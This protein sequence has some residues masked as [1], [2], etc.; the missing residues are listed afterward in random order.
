MKIKFCVA[1]LFLLLNVLFTKAQNDSLSMFRSSDKRNNAAKTYYKNVLFLNCG[2]L[3]RGGFSI[4]YER[5][6]LFNGVSIFAQAG[7]TARDFTGQF[8]WSAFQSIFDNNDSDR[9]GLR[10]GYM[11][12]VGA[13]YYLQKSDNGKYFS[14]S[15]ANIVNTRVRKFSPNIIIDNVSNNYYLVDYLSR[16]IKV[17]YGTSSDAEERFYSDWAIGSGL[18]FLKYDNAK[19]TTIEQP[20]SDTDYKYVKWLSKSVK[21]DVTPWLYFTWKIGFRF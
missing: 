4:G 7:Y 13:K 2:T 15:Y 6:F 17:M 10:P 1:F 20:S 21:K 9:D 12:E 16:E 11:Y 8:D 19:F 5:H 18:R 3:F 14:L